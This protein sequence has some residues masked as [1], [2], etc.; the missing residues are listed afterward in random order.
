MPNQQEGTSFMRAFAVF[1]VILTMTT[2]AFAETYR[3]IHAI[4]NDEN[5]VASGLEKDECE[6]RKS[7][8]KEVATAL[9]T[10]NERTGYG[11]ITCLPDSFFE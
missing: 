7:D 3:L 5:V 2:P 8:L 9:G 11:S 6:Q 10:Y 4:G 1:A